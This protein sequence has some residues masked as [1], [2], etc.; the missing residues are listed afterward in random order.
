MFNPWPA[1]GGASNETLEAFSKR[2][3]GTLRH[4]G[5]AVTRADYE[6]LAYE[7]SP[8][9]AVAQVMPT[10]ERGVV[11]LL[12]I[13]YSQEA[14][15]QPSFGLRQQVRRFL[16]ARASV[17]LMETGRIK[18]IGP[19]YCT[20]KVTAT[21]AVLEAHEAKVVEIRAR[22]ALAEFLHPLRGGPEKQ[23]WE[24]GRDVH[25]SDIAALL[26]HIPGV[27]YV[28]RLLLSGGTGSTGERV[29]VPEL[30]IVVAGQVQLTLKSSRR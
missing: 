26:E 11:T 4:R 22:E 1:E 28:E 23:G 15:P 20:V 9:V 27:D 21:L 13:P 18:V 6:A 10:P 7:A 5:R 16:E 29:E 2:A 25:L 19:T 24:L 30:Q 17:D 3:P 12:I 8:A 14:Q